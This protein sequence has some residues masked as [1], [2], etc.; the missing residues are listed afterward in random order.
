M[1]N[2]ERSR[3]LITGATGFIGRAIINRLLKKDYYQIIAAV[4]QN[5]VTFPLSIVLNNVGD[6]TSETKWQ[7][8]LYGVE[9]VIHTAARAHVL[10]EESD[11]PL[12]EFRKVNVVATLNLARQAVRAGVR[13]FIFISS[14]GVNGNQNTQPFTENDTP[15]PVEP[16]AVSKLEAEQELHKLEVET[17][18]DVVIIRPPLV[19]GPK[20]PGNFERLLRIIYTGLPLPLGAIKNKRS[21]VALDNLVDLIVTCINHPAAANQ[22]FLAGDG[23]DLSTTEL[24]QRIGQALGKPVRLIPVP[25]WL[26]VAGAGLFGKRAVVQQLCGSLQVDISKAK[27][28]LDWMPPVSVEETLHETALDF[29]TSKST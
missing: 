11:N 5:S 10:K 2:N 21:L 17:S 27:N 13:R 16:Y 6:L 3:I 26:L 9:V 20:A 1:R 15:N 4:R 28:L 18:M 12:S 22:T 8:A 29:L 25:E 23:V 7:E 14:I 24:L 19:Y